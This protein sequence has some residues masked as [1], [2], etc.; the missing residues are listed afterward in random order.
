MKFDFNA[1]IVNYKRIQE[2][3]NEASEDLAEAADHLLQKALDEDEVEIA[4]Y[5]IKKVP[6]IVTK[7]FMIDKARQTWSDFTL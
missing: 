5:L 3:Y 4:K 2:D 1:L 6:C 7:A